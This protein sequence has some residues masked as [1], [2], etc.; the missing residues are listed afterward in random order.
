MAELTN[1]ADRFLT[2][3][4]KLDLLAVTF[5]DQNGIGALR[6][7][8]ARGARV[9]SCS[10]FVEQLLSLEAHVS[11]SSIQP[12]EAEFIARLRARDE[13]AFEEMVLRF[14]GRM[15]SVAR[16]FL[17]SEDDARDA[18]QEAFLSAF[19]SIDQFSG[20][21]ML[22]TWLHRIVV[23]AALMQLRRRRRKPEHSIDELL[24]RFDADGGW[25]EDCGTASGTLEGLCEARETNKMVW[26]CIAKLPETYRVVLLLRDIEDL[27]TVEAAQRCGISPNGVKVRLHRARQAL[28]TLVERE[29]GALRSL[30][31][32]ENAPANAA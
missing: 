31:R 32:A 11:Q 16:R 18:V 23:N 4:I 20:S 24:P 5:A 21:A 8:I 25:A 3:R 15:L 13:A 26:R 19:E 17:S 9:E 7:L 12:S 10:G 1:T 14:G 2:D 6:S 27:D 30:S 22:S 28:R 29:A